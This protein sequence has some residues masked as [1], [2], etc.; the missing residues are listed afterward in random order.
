M[1]GGAHT[2][3]LLSVP[4]NVQVLQALEEEPL[5]LIDLRRALGSPPQTTMR[6]HLRALDELGIVGRRRQ[7][8]FPGSIDYQLAAPG[9]ELLFVAKVLDAWLDTAPEGA[10]Q[11]GSVGA[12]SAIKA[13][14]DGWSSTIVRALAAR[15][16]SLTELN[17]IIASFNYPS[18]ERRLGAMRLASQIEARPG[19]TRGTPYAVTDWMRRAVAPL[20]AALRWEQRHPSPAAAPI[21]RLDVESIFLLT[22]PL[23][24]LRP[25]L[26]GVCRLAVEVE[27]SEGGPGPAG[28]VV[29]VEQG[30]VVSCLSRLRAEV[31]SW[32]WGTSPAW[33]GAMIGDEPDQLELGGNGDLA[34]A[35]VDGVHEALFEAK[36]RT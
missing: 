35:L 31:D 23:V 10:L 6:S 30:R 17:Q 28:V 18:L 27:S 20:V 25:E 26:E 1:R 15:P 22:V 9:T 12:K 8:G 11:L 34:A 24:D 5:S 33:I 29:S 7:A 14:V 4:L 36:Q 19:R 2:L 13:L 16:L 32:A 21:S 3:T